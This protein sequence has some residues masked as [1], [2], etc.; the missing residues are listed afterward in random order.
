MGLTMKGNER[1]PVEMLPG[2][3]V[4]QIASGGDHLAMLTESGQVSVLSFIYF[5]ARIFCNRYIPADL[6]LRM[7]RT[8]STRKSYS[9]FLRSTQSS[10]IK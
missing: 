10:R 3:K 7:R 9:S 8:R 6:Y 1:I 2:H 5:I 4:T